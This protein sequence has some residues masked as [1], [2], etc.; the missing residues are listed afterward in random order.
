M[1]SAIHGFRHPLVGAGELRTYPLWLMASTA[2]ITIFS[3]CTV[4]ETINTTELSWSDYLVVSVLRSFL[5]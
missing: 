5:S 4:L 2:L 3:C 1:V